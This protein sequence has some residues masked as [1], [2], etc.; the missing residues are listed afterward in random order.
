VQFRPIPELKLFAE[1]RYAIESPRSGYGRS[2][3]RIGA[4]GG[5][6]RERSIGR[7]AIFSDS[8]GELMFIPRITKRPGATIFSKVGPR[9][10]LKPNFGADLYL[11]GFARESDD[12]NLGRRAY[13]LRYGGRLVYSFSGPRATSNWVATAGAFH[14]FAS[15]RDAPEARWRLI[16]AI[17]GSL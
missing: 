14:R 9:F 4:V 5:L 16:V 15:F 13:E 11:E 10:R 2:D 6:W 8:Y 1:Y 12:L 17:G 3:P 7:H